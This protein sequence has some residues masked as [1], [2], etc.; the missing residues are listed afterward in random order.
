MSSRGDR[1]PSKPESNSDEVRNDKVLPQIFHTFQVIGDYHF[2]HFLR[3]LTYQIN[4]VPRADSGSAKH[5]PV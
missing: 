4:K 3:I 5:M 1:D 2:W